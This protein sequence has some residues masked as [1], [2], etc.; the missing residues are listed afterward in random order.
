M[1]YMKLKTSERKDLLSD[2]EEMPNFLASSFVHL[3]K[4]TTKKRSINGG[5][6]PIEHVWHL[7]DLEQEGFAVRLNKLLKTNN[8]N[9]PDFE[10]G[11]IAKERNY[12][13]LNLSDGLKAFSSAR[14]QNISTIKQINESQ[15]YKE[16]NLEGVGSIT[17][18][19]LPEMLYQHD[20]EHKKE[21]K[22][23]LNESA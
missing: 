21:I 7:A 15:W 9:L 18:C 14:K 2:L 20:S 10:G 4:D 13:S 3:D 16:G 1:K 5:F 11:K 17:L 23:W 19:D 22:A 6:S 12:R 8:P